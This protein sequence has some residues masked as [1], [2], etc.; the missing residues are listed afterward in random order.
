MRKPLSTAAKSAS[1]RSPAKPAPV[2]TLGASQSLARSANP[3]SSARPSA[4]KPPEPQPRRRKLFFAASL[5]LLTSA[6]GAV[7]YLELWPKYLCRQ[8]EARAA[9]ASETDA[10]YI[11]DRLEGCG[12]LGTTALV[13]LLAFE[14]PH[15]AQAA[16]GRLSSLCRNLRGTAPGEELTEAGREQLQALAAGL[17][18]LAHKYQH[19]VPAPVADF[20]WQALELTGRMSLD[21]RVPMLAR[22]RLATVSDQLLQRPTRPR[23]VVAADAP[24]PKSP[25]PPPTDAATQHRL[26]AQRTLA[27]LYNLPVP[28][29]APNAAT[30]PA[31]LPTAMPATPLAASMPASTSGSINPNEAG[32]ASTPEQRSVANSAARI[33]PIRDGS[34][35]SAIQ[36]VSTAPP[37]TTD[38]ES[39]GASS[40]PSAALQRHLTTRSAWALLGDLQEAGTPQASAA[41]A[42]LHRRG[43]SLREIEIGKHLTSSDPGERTRYTEML[44]SAGIAVKPWLLYLSGDPDADVRRAAVAIMATSNDPELRAKL[45]DLAITDADEA[46]R[47]QAAKAGRPA[48][49]RAP[50]GY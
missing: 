44:P 7:G 20:A 4:T 25:T 24:T 30:A 3:P 33:N 38:V 8:W 26:A 46:V 2:A 15:V 22:G 6:V 23:T 47:N 9:T 28:A 12:P 29:T 39:S 34:E 16:Y 21:D 49:M 36:Q 45:R 5:S 32:S 14:R 37:R 40:S 18:E 19:E 35:P 13:R 42:E 17:E 27:S 43:F 50:S 41:A 48:T 10:E 31:G 1:F 11:V